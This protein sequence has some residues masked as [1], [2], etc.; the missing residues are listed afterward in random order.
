MKIV[1]PEDVSGTCIVNGKRADFEV[2]AGS[3]SSKS[4]DD[5][6]VF[7]H[8]VDAG[9]ATDPD[10]LAAVDGR[11]TRPTPRTKSRKPRGARKPQASP[12]EA[13]AGDT[14]PIAAASVADEK[15]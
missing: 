6:D 12:T 4:H 13:S 3:H 1:V 7:Q 8:L 9:L 14:D 10:A 15:E 11:N 2:K 5:I